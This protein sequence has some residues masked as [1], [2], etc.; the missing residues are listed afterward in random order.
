MHWF[1]VATVFVVLALLG[2]GFSV[3]AFVNPAAS[4]LEPES[5]LKMLSRSALVLEKV[6]PVGYSVYSLFFVIQ[7][8]LCWH[9]KR[10]VEIPA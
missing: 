3:S 7:T 2:V 9:T 8:W 1:N 5:H 4:R 6:M 10:T